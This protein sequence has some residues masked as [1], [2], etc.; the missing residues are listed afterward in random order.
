MLVGNLIGA[1]INFVVIGFV[2]WRIAKAF[3]KPKGM[4][5]RAGER[6]SSP[7]SHLPS[8]ISIR[9]AHHHARPPTRTA[10]MV[11]PSRSASTSSRLAPIS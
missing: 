11:S 2:C 7:I 8:Q 3:V 1:L 6:S 10:V 4:M 9:P 5:E